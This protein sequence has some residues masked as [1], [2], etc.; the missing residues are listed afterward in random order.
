MTSTNID[1]AP[2]S[3]FDD[4]ELET[5]TSVNED[6]R[7]EPLKMKADVAEGSRLK[8]LVCF[9]GIFVS[10]FFYG[11]VQEKVTRGKYGEGAEA[12][13]FTYTLSLVFSQCIINA[14][15]A[16]AVIQYVK[17]SP[18]TTL[19]TYYAACSFTYIGA[20]VG[21]NWALR[22]VSYPT[23][24]LGKSCKPIPVMILGVIFAR[25]RYNLAKYLCVLLIV[26]G[27]TLFMYK[28]NVSSKDD[29]HTFGMGEMLLIL[30]L[31]LDGATGAIQE[32]MRSEHKTAPHPMMFNMN[33]WSMLYLAVG[34]LLTGEA[35]PF[36][37]FVSRHPDVIPLMV[38]F[39]CT[40]AIGQIFI[41]ITVSVYGP[42]MCSIITTTRKF[43]TILASVII[44][45]NPLLAR[46]WL[47]VLMVFAGLGVDSVYGKTQTKPKPKSKEHSENV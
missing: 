7:T 32:R 13:Y 16:K 36:L 37:G 47:G 35:I 8:L 10:Y 29:D 1:K 20:M 11:L 9:L 26:I 39:G 18:D 45:V 12:E 28:D 21:S 6:T 3:D 2:V 23:Q 24:V 40:S 46:Q 4:V 44:F 15:V 43:F 31:T 14:L 22:Y 38:L 17:P 34:I 33:L 19:N 41:F 30:S 25:K 42:L 5:R 27:I